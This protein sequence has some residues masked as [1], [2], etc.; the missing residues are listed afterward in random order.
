MNQIEWE[1]H[2]RNLK[3]EKERY[4]LSSQLDRGYIS[5]SATGHQILKQQVEHVADELLDLSR[6]KTRGVGGKY[7][8]VLREVAQFYK[9]DGTVYEDYK[10]IAYIGMCVCI[11]NLFHKARER[12][13]VSYIASRIGEAL[14]HERK[15][16]YFKLTDPDFIHLQKLEQA[17]FKGIRHK[18]IVALKKSLARADRD[19]NEWGA[20]VRS[21]IGI[22]VLKAI[23]RV[24]EEYISVKTIRTTG[25]KEPTLV[26]T[27]AFYT[28][29]ADHRDYLLGRIKHSVP[30]IDRPIPWSFE[31]GDITGGFHSPDLSYHVPFIKGKT[32]SQRDRVHPPTLNNHIAA[33]NHLQ[34]TK[35]K[36]NQPVFDLLKLSM[37]NGMFRD[38][39]SLQ[40]LEYSERPPDDHPD[41]KAWG[42]EAHEIYKWNKK[43]TEHLLRFQHLLEIG[44]FF[45]DKPMWFVYNTDFRGRIYCNSSHLNPQGPDHVRGMLQFCN[46][47]ELGPSGYKWLAVHGANCYGYDKVSYADRYRW[48]M[49]NMD[50]ILATA[51]KPDSSAG[52]ELLNGASKPFQFYAFCKEW[53][54]LSQSKVPET[55]I[56]HLPVA[57]DGSCNGLQHSAALLCDRNG[58]TS[59]NLTESEL[60]NDF[61]QDVADELQ[62]RITRDPDK[63]MGTLLPVLLDRTVVKPVVMN[64][65][66]GITRRG[67]SLSLKDSLG[68]DEWEVITYITEKVVNSCEALAPSI[69]QLQEWLSEVSDAFAKQDK[70]VNW[71][72][73]TGFYVEQPYELYTEEI[74]KTEFFGSQRLTY[75][76]KPH[77]VM[78]SKSRAGLAPNLI[79]SLDAA[80]LVMTINKAK[81]LGMND[82]YVV[83]DEFGVH[84]AD[85]HKF[86]ECI[87]NAFCELYI[88]DVLEGLYRQWNEQVPIPRPPELGDYDSTEVLASPYFFG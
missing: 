77:G 10:K 69:R 56:S 75:R 12:S 33:C 44:N 36:L 16:D 72:S 9:S 88:P 60:P 28:Y 41:R 3:I 4:R 24:M 43:N 35:W 18:R 38:I 79:H 53:A 64:I 46:G 82:F 62:A 49:D 54:A 81:A 51:S 32:K 76:D 37:K 63:L 30:C 48:V 68:L 74:I 27:D 73:P 21:Q 14:E 2:S 55:F 71:Y 66:Y 57:L 84:A 13:K 83:H 80:H 78:R 22:R 26:P 23:L 17:E 25:R 85:T 6:R 8:Q 50:R 70:K 39:P 86:R 31:S 7:A 45:T 67:I 58:A 15:I 5:D 59:V 40:K 47:K 34:A 11:D 42:Q 52:R 87:N 61:Y 65:P 20:R 29:I 1:Q 19:W